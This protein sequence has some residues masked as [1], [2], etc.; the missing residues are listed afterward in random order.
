MEIEEKNLKKYEWNM[1][2][3]CDTIKRPALQMMG[4]EGGRGTSRG[5]ENIFNGITAKIPDIEKGLQ[6]RTSPCHI[7][8]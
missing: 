3:L 7:I 2:D 1:Q 6:K 5:I 8:V 4:T